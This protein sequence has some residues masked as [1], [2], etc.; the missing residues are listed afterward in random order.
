MV[1]GLGELLNVL[2]IWFCLFVNVKQN[3]K[4]NL[5]LQLIS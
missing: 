2:I 3:C 4:N 1:F 5:K